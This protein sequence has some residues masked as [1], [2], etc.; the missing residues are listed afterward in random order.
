[1]RLPSEA[2]WEYVARGGAAGA[3]YGAVEDIAWYNANA[4][5]ATHSVAQKQPNAFGV[6]DMLGNVREW[7]ADWYGPYTAADV[8]DPQG[9]QIGRFR[10]G[11]GGSWHDSAQIARASS[12]GNNGGGCGPACHG[13]R[14]AAN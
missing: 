8:I 14:C 6:Y 4:A 7:V 9:P 10:V 12:R 3:R 1:M 5:S 2:E 13:F 11:R